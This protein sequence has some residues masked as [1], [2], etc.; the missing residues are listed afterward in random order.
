MKIT[1]TKPEIYETHGPN[2]GPQFEKDKTYDLRDDL[3]QRW[4]NRKSAVPAKTNAKVEDMPTYNPPED[5][6]PA[7]E[8]APEPAEESAKP[9]ATHVA[10]TDN[11]PAARGTATRR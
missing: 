8:P 10:T 9:A 11:T 7:A 1:F 6:V 4:I 3:A 5:V 2:K